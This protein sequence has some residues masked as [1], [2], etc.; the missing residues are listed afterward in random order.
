[1]LE[2]VGHPRAVNPDRALRKIARARRWP[3]LAFGGRMAAQP[4]A[5]GQ[6][7]PG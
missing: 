1:M 5:A 3:A 2:A 6:G 4:P 7:E